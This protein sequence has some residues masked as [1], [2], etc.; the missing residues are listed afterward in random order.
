MRVGGETIGLAHAI[1]G[2]YRATHRVT[3]IPTLSIRADQQR[4]S[5]VRLETPSASL[6]LT[7]TLNAM[8]NLTAFGSYSQTRSSD[9]SM[10]SSASKMTSVST[11]SYL[12]TPR[13]RTTL[14]VDASYTTLLEPAHQTE[15]L[16]G[17]CGFSSPVSKFTPRKLYQPRSLRHQVPLIPFWRYMC[18]LQEI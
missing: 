6:A 8:L 2:S 14:S 5:G 3:L 7:Y 9:G 1:S 4:W 13:L 15:D 11:W 16:P 10:D 18:K 12:K 17:Y